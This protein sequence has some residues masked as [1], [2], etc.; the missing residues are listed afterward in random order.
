MSSSLHGRS[1]G[2]PREALGALQAAVRGH[3]DYPL[4]YVNLARA[5]I[6]LGRRGSAHSLR[7]KSVGQVGMQQQAVRRAYTPA[8]PLADHDQASRQVQ[9]ALA[10]SSPK[11]AKQPEPPDPA[12]KLPGS[13]RHDKHPMPHST[14]LFHRR[15]TIHAVEESARVIV[16]RQPRPDTFG[17]V[18]VQPVVRDDPQDAHVLFPTVASR[19]P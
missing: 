16:T 18:V 19:Y 14:P 4:T 11:S 8:D 1:A 5:S 15:E 12:W 9:A 13:C 2:R 6:D 7:P 10:P 17:L 3:A